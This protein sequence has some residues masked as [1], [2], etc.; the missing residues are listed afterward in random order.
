M[1]T[2]KETGEKWVVL[3][4]Q[5]RFPIGEASF[6]EIPAGMLDNTGK[7]KGQV[8]AKVQAEIEEETGIK[9]D[10]D[11]LRHLG[12]AYMS[13]GGS[14]ELIYFYAI[15]L[16][17]SHEEIMG[18]QGKHTGLREEREHIVVDICPFK[19]VLN[20]AQTDA[21]AIVAYTL[22]GAVNATR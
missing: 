2:E 20:R 12:E 8:L 10:A 22:Y 21:K 16:T 1:I 19:D 14:D 7:M 4:R 11:M 3:T 17:L 9:I 18:L 13:P 15:D 5:A 6:T